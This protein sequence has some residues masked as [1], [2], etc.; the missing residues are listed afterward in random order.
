MHSE[1]AGSFLSGFHLQEADVIRWGSSSGSQFEPV[2]DQVSGLTPPYLATVYHSQLRL[3]NDIICEFWGYFC[4]YF[5]PISG[6]FCRG[7]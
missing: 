4:P 3:S 6:Q 7:S 5:A 2:Y 1:G